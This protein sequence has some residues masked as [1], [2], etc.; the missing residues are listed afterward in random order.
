MP[1][2]NLE[3]ILPLEDCD[4]NAPGLTNIYV[5]RVADIVSI[6]APD[7][8]TH[9]ISADIVLASGKQFF[10]FS[11]TEGTGKHMEAPEGEL[12]ARSWSESLQ[13]YIP[14]DRERVTYIANN[15]LGGKY[16]AVRRDNNGL[17]KVVGSLTNPLRLQDATLDTGAGGADKN[18]RQF[19]LK[20]YPNAPHAAYE[21]TGAIPL[22]PVP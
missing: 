8:N 14:K 11:F 17:I 19:E 3:P 9:T 18:G 4:S 7:A 5:A 16:I 10:E 6:P 21:Y 20:M 2:P 13:L 12:D 22:T 15:M 1:C